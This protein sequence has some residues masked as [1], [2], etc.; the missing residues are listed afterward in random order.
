MNFGLPLEYARG[1]ERA[2][3]RS[4]APVL[5][6]YFLVALAFWLWRWRMALLGVQA[7]CKI[8]RCMEDAPKV[9]AMDLIRDS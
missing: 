3:T 1:R 2:V 8:M 5:S 7:M 9:A 4:M 6:L